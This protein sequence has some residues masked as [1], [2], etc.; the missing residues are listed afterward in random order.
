MRLT[1]SLEDL[2]G[3]VSAC[4]KCH[5]CTYGPWPQNHGFCPIYERGR[6]FTASAGGLLYLAKAVLNGQMDYNASLAEL[7]YTCATCGACDDRCSIVRSVNP[8]MALSDIIRL[9]RHELVKRGFAPDGPI[10]QMYEHV[11]RTGNLPSNGRAKSLPIPREN[12]QAD[13]LLVADCLHTDTEASACTAALGLLA[14]MDTRVAVCAESGCCGSTLYDFG[15]WDEL[16]ALVTKQWKKI[17]SFGNKVLLFVNPHCQEFITNKYPKIL[18]G[19]FKP[20]Q[21]KHISEALLDG[22]TQGKLKT[23]KMSKMTVSYHDPCFLGRGL[24]LYEP[25]RQVLEHLDGV[26]LVEMKRNRE[27]SF[28]CGARGLGNYFDNFSE[29]TAKARIKEFLDTKADVMIT[30]CAY[31]KERFRTVMGSEAERVQD[32]TEF[33]GQRVE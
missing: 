2:R 20:F 25:P 21:G 3:S 29:D 7:A 26:H 10:K 27:Q 4:L 15:F 19:E 24:G 12:G 13:M 33:V 16:P 11:K 31:C 9:L 22:L 18:N 23:K 32:L 14:K 17:Q 5:G 1:T 8:E 6:T 28:C 30:A